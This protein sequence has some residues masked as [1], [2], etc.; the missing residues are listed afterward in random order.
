V[1]G[2]DAVEKCRRL[3]PDLVV[4]DIG[5]PRLNGIDAARQILRSNPNQRILVLTDV[6]AEH[7]IRECLE[8]GARGW[9]FKNDGADDLIAAVGALE[10]HRSTF[11]SRVSDLVLDGYVRRPHIDAPFAMPRELGAREREVVQLVAE[12]K[13][14]KEIAVMLGVSVKTVETHRSNI[15]IKL[16]IHSTVEVVM[17]AVRNGIVSVKFPDAADARPPRRE[18]KIPLSDFCLATESARCGHVIPVDDIDSPSAVHCACAA[19]AAIHFLTGQKETVTSRSE[20]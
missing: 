9:I 2:R 19:D 6:D 17:Y 15:L 3:K 12:G 5:M 18:R 8:A 7:V 16:K 1:D 20:A 13:T 14:S 4:L 10:Q 11:S